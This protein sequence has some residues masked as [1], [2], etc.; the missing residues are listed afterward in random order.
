MPGYWELRGNP[1]RVVVTGARPP[2]YYYAPPVWSQ[3]GD[4]WYLT[5]VAG[6]VAI[7]MATAYQTA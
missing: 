1:A 5:A 6:G 4:C 7:V 3:R 2:G